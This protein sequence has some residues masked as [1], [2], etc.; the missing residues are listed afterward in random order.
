MEKVIERVILFMRA[1]P[2]NLGA[3][4]SEEIQV[5]LYRGHKR[6]SGSPSQSVLQTVV[7]DTFSDAVRAY[8]FEFTMDRSSDS[9]VIEI[10]PKPGSN[11]SEFQGVIER[12]VIRYSVHG[13]NEMLF[14]NP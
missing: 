5:N 10:E 4:S 3:S 14:V 1:D 2:D 7:Y 8:H 6:S 9:F 13:E 12:I 11:T